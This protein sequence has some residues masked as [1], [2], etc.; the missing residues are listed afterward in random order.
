M[1]MKSGAAGHSEDG[2]WRLRS[3][4]VVTNAILWQEE[5][6]SSTARQGR[7]TLQSLRSHGPTVCRRDGYAT[8]AITILHVG[9][10]KTRP[11]GSK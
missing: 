2:P 11:P 7:G 6:G 9:G 10:R 4:L 1:R 8:S 3:D 5:E